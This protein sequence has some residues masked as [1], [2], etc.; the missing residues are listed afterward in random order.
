[1]DNYLTIVKYQLTKLYEDLH[2]FAIQNAPTQTVVCCPNFSEGI[3][4]LLYLVGPSD[5]EQVNRY[6]GSL[7]TP[8][9]AFGDSLVMF[10]LRHVLTY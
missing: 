8:L 7:L 6:G 1:M 10:I 3:S 9:R 4:S 2:H 5:Q